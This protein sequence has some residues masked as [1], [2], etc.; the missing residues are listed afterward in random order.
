MK[1]EQGSIKIEFHIGLPSEAIMV[2]Q[3]Q[4]LPWL[5]ECACWSDKPE[6]KKL[7][8]TSYCLN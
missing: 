7:I 6:R 3:W 4:E 1:S 5:F 8:F 2:H